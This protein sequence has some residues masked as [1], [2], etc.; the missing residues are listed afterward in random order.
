MVDKRAALIVASMDTKGREVE[1]L[2]GCFR[3]SGVAVLTIDAGILGEAPFPVTVTR[4]EVAFAGGTPL[5]DLQKE[6]DEGKAISVM[7]KGAAVWAQRLYRDGRI[8]GIISIGGSMGTALATGV[9]RLFP[10]G[11]PKVMISTMASSNTRPYV[12]TRDILMLYSVCDFSGVNRITGRVLRNGAFALAG[13]I[14]GSREYVAPPTPAIA[15]STLGTTEP[16][17]QRIRQAFEEKGYDI[18]VFHTTGT[19]G[20]AMEEMINEGG[21][22]AVI[23]LSLDEIGNHLFGGDYDAGPDR[24]SGA[25]RKGL[26]TVLVPGNVDILGGGPFKMAQ[27]RFPG[28]LHH[29]HNAAITAVRTTQE[30]LEAI[31]NRIASYCNQATGPLACVVPT[32]GFSAFDRKGGPFY[33]PGASRFFADLFGRLLSPVVPLRILPHHINE[34]PFAEAVIAEMEALL[35][36]DGER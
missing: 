14:G 29:V 12:G 5:A 19:G 36:G 11:F 35:S 15:L 34:P 13:M 9:M 1:Y 16:C 33:D 30:E 22:T 32:G 3:E 26:P 17:S 31:A 21:V 28:R 23:D 18:L 27:L 20:E 25:L 2:C 4:E 24:G 8:G 10:V 6:G 7:Q